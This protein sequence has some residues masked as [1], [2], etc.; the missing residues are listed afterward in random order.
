[1]LFINILIKSYTHM[2]HAFQGGATTLK[3]QEHLLLK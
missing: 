1:M 3:T 2:F